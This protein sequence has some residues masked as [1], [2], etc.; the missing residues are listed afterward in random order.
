MAEQE[1]QV[2]VTVVFPCLNEERTLGS[3]I[4]AAQQAFAKAGICGEVLVADNGSTDRSIE[5][6][7]ALGARVVHVLRP[8]YGSA[9]REGLSQ[10][11][12]RYLIFLDADMS[13]DAA[14]IPLFVERLR[15][16]AEVVMGSRFRGGI[17]P[18]AM[19]TLNRY[20]GT[21]LLTLAANILFGCRITDVNCGMRGVTREALDRLDLH[22]EGMEFASEMIIKAAQARLRIDEVPIRFHADQRGRQPH[23][24]P[25]RDGWRHLQVMMHF[26]PMW[27]Y[28]VPSMALVLAGVWG[29]L[30][31]E[32]ELHA[33]TAWAVC[34]LSILSTMLGTQILLLGVTALGRVRSSKHWAVRGRRIYRLMARYVKIEQGLILAVAMIVAGAAIDI[35]AVSGFGC[36]AEFAGGSYFKWMAFGVALALNGLQLFTLCLF[37]GLFGIRVADDGRQL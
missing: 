19:P 16:G 8:G 35:F 23:L 33:R 12:S 27:I 21:P 30:S 20:V 15:A 10:A 9:L 13:Y 36:G 6:A 18:G 29:I 34:L 17:D 14:H 25:M 11:R 28:V 3:C 2:E 24:R 37:L 22:S 26:C 4:E 7:A 5:I 1:P 31:A 32:P